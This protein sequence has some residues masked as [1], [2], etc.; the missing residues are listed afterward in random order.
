MRIEH[1]P[2][3]SAIRFCARRGRYPTTRS[4]CGWRALR[5][6]RRSGP[7]RRQRAA[8]Q[9]PTGP[10]YPS[11]SIHPCPSGFGS[12]RMHLTARLHPP[13]ISVHISLLMA[14]RLYDSLTRELR[15]LEAV[16]A[17]RRVPHVLLRADRLRPGAHR[18]FSHVSGPGC[19]A[20]APGARF[21][22]G[23]GE[24]CPQ[25]HGRRRPHHRPGETRAAPA[26]RNHPALDGD[27]PSRLRRAEHAAAARRA[28]RDRPH[29]RT[30][31]DDR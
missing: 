14:I 2:S 30:G 28:H 8:L 11:A 12:N 26:R 13:G 9:I 21:W 17:R 16:A 23:Q 1:T 18:Q 5:R 19:V 25:S 27:L 31:R 20:A 15:E 24:A 4:L 7:R 3:P 22:P 10:R 6:Q 29:R